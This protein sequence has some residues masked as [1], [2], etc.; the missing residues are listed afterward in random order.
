[1]NGK[2]RPKVTKTKKGTEK[3]SRNKDKT[4][5]KM[6]PNIYLSI[7]TLNIN[8]LNIPIKRQHVRVNKK[9]PRSIY[10]LPTR[11]E[12]NNGFE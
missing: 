7:I 11:D 5:N 8:G 1:M 3:N 9:K 6:A 10:M 4:T 2:E 12:V